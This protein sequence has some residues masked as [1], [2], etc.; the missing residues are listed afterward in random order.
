MNFMNKLAGNEYVG[1]SNAT[2]VQW[3]NPLHVYYTWIYAFRLSCQSTGYML[4]LRVHHLCLRFQSER[5]SGDR[6]FAIG[7]Y[8]KEKKVSTSFC[9][10]SPL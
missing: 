6:N 10:L 9:I 7:Y 8:L 5:E 1:F 2:Y 3:H 4:S